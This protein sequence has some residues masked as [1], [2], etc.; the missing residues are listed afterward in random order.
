MGELTRTNQLLL[1]ALRELAVGEN[2]EKKVATRFSWADIFA[3]D[4]Q[5]DENTWNWG[6]G[7]GEADADNK[8]NFSITDFLTDDDYPEDYDWR[9]TIDE[10]EDNKPH[11]I[12]TERKVASKKS[13][14]NGSRQRRRS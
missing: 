8:P 6:D 10:P 2:A 12:W 13:K 9:H 11:W 4:N 7:F 3:A 1:K 14:T 5:D